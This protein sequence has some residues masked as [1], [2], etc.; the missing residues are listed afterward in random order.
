MIDLYHTLA[1]ASARAWPWVLD[2]LWQSTLF[3]LALLPAA[4]LMKRAPA[5]LR[6]SLSLAASLK[7]A[8]PSVV[9]FLVAIRLAPEVGGLLPA[10]SVFTL[11]LDRWLASWTGSSTGGPPS[12]GHLGL[13][14]AATVI[15]LAGALAVAWRWR[16]R[17]LAFVRVLSSAR[18]LEHGAEAELL[19]AVQARLGIRRPVRL[20]LLAGGV[21]PGV[22]RVWRPVL[23]LP[24][25]MPAVLSKAELEAIF[26]HE[27]THV[28]R[29]DNLVAS[30]HMVLCCVLWFHPLVWWLDRRL[31]AE[32]EEACDER[33]LA[34]GGRAETYARSLVK[35]V[36]LGLGWRLAGVS[37]ASASN[38]RRRI[39]RILAHRA[40]RRSSLAQRAVLASVVP[41]LL[42]FSVASGTGAPPASSPEQARQLEAEAASS[43]AAERSVAPAPAHA[44]A[45]VKLACRNKDKSKRSAQPSRVV[46]QAAGEVPSHPSLDTVPMPE[47]QVATVPLTLGNPSQRGKVGKPLAE[48]ESAVSEEARTAVVH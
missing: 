7:F 1:A 9:F 12:A 39:E 41:L 44:A 36:G 29:Y 40:I 22:F 20:A 6:Y 13:Y 21:E 10:S 19:A 46:P 14:A 26:L 38:F 18:T 2:H 42:A 31:L 5:G 34:M 48:E 3:V 28:R 17:T 33:V 16:R 45:P 8:L 30:L 32:R 4:A 35:A 47:V 43:T 25:E 15:W 11:G 23:V 24:E 37:S 27:L